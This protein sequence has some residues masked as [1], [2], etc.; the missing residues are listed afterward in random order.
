MPVIPGLNLKHGQAHTR[1]RGRVVR[2][3]TDLGFEE[4]EI[5]RICNSV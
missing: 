2:A 4:E 3:I 5:C 1:T